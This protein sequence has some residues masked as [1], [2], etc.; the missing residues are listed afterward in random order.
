MSCGR[1]S[2]EINKQP[3]IKTGTWRPRRTRQLQLPL[4][5]R[6]SAL[7]AAWATGAGDATDLGKRRRPPPLPP[8]GRPGLAP[9]AGWGASGR[10]GSL[11]RTGL[12]NLGC[13]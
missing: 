10:E 9:Q 5:K 7:A 13:A 12:Y 11:P 1:V 3:V 8:A 4:T 6:R 2:I